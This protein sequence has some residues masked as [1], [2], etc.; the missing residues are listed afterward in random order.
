MTP[1]QKQSIY[2]RPDTVTDENG[3][4]VVVI[5]Q[6]PATSIAVAQKW[7]FDTVNINQPYSYEY[8]IRVKREIAAIAII[9]HCNNGYEPTQDKIGWM[10]YKELDAQS[11]KWHF[12]NYAVQLDNALFK[13]LN[14]QY[15][16]Y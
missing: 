2:E 9:T 5:M 1:Q 6:C 8:G 14:L 16:K 3:N 11:K 12:K 7:A 4:K 10:S 13:K 15:Y